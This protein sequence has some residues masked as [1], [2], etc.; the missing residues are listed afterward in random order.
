M[1]R[2][3]TTVKKKKREQHNSEKEYAAGG[4]REGVGIRDAFRTKTTDKNL[5]TQ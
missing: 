3:E 4:G 2:A 5:T 1:K